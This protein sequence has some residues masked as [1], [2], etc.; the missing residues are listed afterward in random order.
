MRGP[1]Q[2][3]GIRT[4]GPVLNAKQM[5]SVVAAI[6]SKRGFA[7]SSGI[8]WKIP[9]DLRMFRS[10]TR[11]HAVIMGRKTWDSLPVRPLPGRVNVV[12]SRD[13]DR[14]FPGA[15]KAATLTEA[16]RL[17][18][19]KRAFAIG[20]LGVFEEALHRN[21][22]VYLT[23]VHADLGCT[24]FFPP[25]A[26]FRCRGTPK[27]FPGGV[28]REGN[29]EYEFFEYARDGH[30]EYQYLDL[31]SKVILEGNRRME[32]T[33]VGA[34]SLF[35][36]TMRFDLTGGVVPVFTTKRV[37]WRGV[38]EELLWFLRGSTDANA[39]AA[40]G[41]RIWDANGS[42][43]FLE[44]RGLGHRETG[45]LGPVYGFQWRHFGAEYGTMRDD[46]TGQGV[47]QIAELVRAIKED[48]ASRRMVVS[49]WN[50]AALDKMA[51]PPCH[52]FAQFFVAK[53]KLS[54][55]MYQRS[56]DMGLGVPF[57]VAS[58]SLL[59]HILAHCTGLEAGTFT[60]V[61]GDCHVY[62]NHVQPLRK[63]L[64]RNP[65]AFPRVVLDPGQRS[66]DDIEASH[67]ELKGYT[68]HPGI[69]MEMAV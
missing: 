15:K 4:R 25:L 27:E 21:V 42:K 19:D 29:L 22:T 46:Y 55:A 57:N 2:F 9:E 69:K 51:L 20:G 17:C 33:G 44:S 7:D 54:C 14:K 8:P 41:V 61:I 35:G 18:G 58:Y 45:D 38:V 48:P 60:H 64:E 1:R 62:L 13:S 30:D 6:D 32:R 26:G 31:L 59:T 24:K 52:M 67:I 37:F 36:R 34:L 53:G 39:L 16:I 10:L 23:R 5:L 56:A 50:P 49:A 28:R 66:V 68:P 12:L 11:G 43:E 63:Q 47:D 40:K 3:G 65:R